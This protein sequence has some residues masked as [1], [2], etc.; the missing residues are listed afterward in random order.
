[1]IKIAKACFWMS[2]A[3][4][5]LGQFVTFY[6]GA[7]LGWFALAAFLAI[8]GF[9]VLKRSFRCA[10]LVLLVLWCAISFLGYTRGKEYEQWLKNNP[11][12]ERI[13]ESQEQLRLKELNITEEAE[14]PQH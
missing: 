3:L 11:L 14:A 10:S 12:E 9:I 6:P 1:M 8:P 4:G 5:I 13:Q 7:E 2:V